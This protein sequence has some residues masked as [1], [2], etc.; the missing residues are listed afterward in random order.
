MNQ[1]IRRFITDQFDRPWLATDPEKMNEDA[2]ASDYYLPRKSSTVYVHLCKK[3]RSK[4]KVITCRQVF[5]AQKD[6]DLPLE[7]HE[8]LAF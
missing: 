2:P 5:L 6:D 4:L 3:L 1:T 7:D 8:L